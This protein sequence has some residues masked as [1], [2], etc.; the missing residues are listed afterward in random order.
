MPEIA[1]VHFSPAEPE[2]LPT[3]WE[4]FRA[5]AETQAIAS[6]CEGDAAPRDL[7][8]PI[9]PHLL[10]TSEGTF[11]VARAGDR[12]VGF[13]AA[14][15]RGEVWYLGRLWVD[16]GWRGRGI[17]TR[18]YRQARRATRGAGARVRASLA[19][20]NGGGI[21]VA[22]RDGLLARH[23]VFRLEG[24]S[25]AA[26]KLWG[27]HRPPAAVRLVAY[28]RAARLGQRSPLALLDREARGAARPQ[29]HAYWLADPHRR[30][31]LVWLG[32]RA[33]AYFYVDS[34]G[35]VGP[36]A[37][38]GTDSLLWALRFAA[39]EAARSSGHVGVRLPAVGRP[40]MEALI[41][42]GF[43]LL[44]GQLLLATAG[45]GKPENYV[46]VDDVLF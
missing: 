41:G 14:V 35:E 28:D 33:V 40:A 32:R 44:G 31:F 38:A 25:E 4:A 22:L 12:I 5:T 46:P 3:I 37:A 15:P 11:L 1:G 26:D 8:P 30:G 43:R 42:A 10:A 24:N 27:A 9:F 29:D 17:G 34:H 36:V 16:P 45:F 23:P 6:L 18:L 39:R 19:G 2:D 21:V 7:P 20:E 13:V